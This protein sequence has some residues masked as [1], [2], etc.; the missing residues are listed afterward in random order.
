MSV[1]VSLIVIFITTDFALPI[2]IIISINCYNNDKKYPSVIVEIFF[3]T[4]SC[5]E[6]PKVLVFT[7][8]TF[9]LKKKIK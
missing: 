8:F 3:S 4:F 1:H 2:N 6:V 5:K 9:L 7:L